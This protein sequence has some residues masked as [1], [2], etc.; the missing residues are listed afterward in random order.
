MKD[1]THIYHYFNPQDKE[2]ALLTFY[3]FRELTD[4]EYQKT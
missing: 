1:F 3:L 4:T 2:N